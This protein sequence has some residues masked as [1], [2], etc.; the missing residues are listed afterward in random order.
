MNLLCKNILLNC[1]RELWYYYEDIYYICNVYISAIHSITKISF[2]FSIYFGR[3]FFY[4]SA[5]GAS[6]TIRPLSPLPIFWFKVSFGL[7][8]S[9]DNKTPFLA[10]DQNKNSISEN[11]SQC[12]HC[13]EPNNPRPDKALLPLPEESPQRNN[14]LS[15]T[16][17]LLYGA[18]LVCNYPK[19]FYRDT[20]A[21]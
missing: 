7:L 15:L 12:G 14:S 13:S 8:R 20:M 6:V 19:W 18:M 11:S 17:G 21:M 1:L 4:I 16:A 10:V 3:G 5:R 2:P 9:A